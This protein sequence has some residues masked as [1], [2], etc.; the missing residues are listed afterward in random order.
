MGRITG[1]EPGGD[2]AGDPR[3]GDTRESCPGESCPDLGRV[4]VKEC[5][6]WVGRPGILTNKLLTANHSKSD[7][8]DKADN[9]RKT[10][11][12]LLKCGLPAS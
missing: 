11:P 5:R 1:G 12:P 3:H 10:D 8:P 7:I 4:I 2:T 9:S 6:L